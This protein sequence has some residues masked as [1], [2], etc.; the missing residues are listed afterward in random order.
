MLECYPDSE[1]ALMRAVSHY[2]SIASSVF[3]GN[4]L[5]IR[6]WN[7]FA[8]WMRP[9]P[10]VRAN[11]GANG[12][13]GQV[14]TWL[15]WTAEVGESWAVVGDLTA[16]Y[17][18]SAPFMLSQVE[19]AGRVLVVIQNN[20]GRIFSRLPRLDSMSPRAAECM[21]NSHSADL[22]GLA[23]LWGMQHLRIRTADDFDRYEAGGETVLLE[24][25]PDAEQTR[26]FWADWDRLV[27]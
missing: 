14:S 16:L 17:D 6:E 27:R 1:P 24:V 12:I 11:R 19:Q 22:A 23:A 7:Q 3:L 2:A 10:V 26:R 15:G 13:D 8:Q 21:I 9:V 4:S 25:I 20:G 5:P 18:L